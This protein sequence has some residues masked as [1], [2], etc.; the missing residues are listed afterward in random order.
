MKNTFTIKVIQRI[1]G[2]IVLAAIIGFSMAACDT[3]QGSTQGSTQA[4]EDITITITGDFS[5]YN[6]WKA[7]IGL[8][9]DKAVAFAMPLNVTGSTTS[10]P[11]TMLR[12]DNNKPFNKSGTY[13]IVL[14]FT[15][16]EEDDSDYVIMNRSIKNGSNSIEFAAFS[17][18]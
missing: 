8:S 1:T 4:K 11:F 5:K 13:M 6:G 14:W 17:S 15:K 7:Y 2:I 10:L 12:M 16:D 3:Q 18:I 9:E